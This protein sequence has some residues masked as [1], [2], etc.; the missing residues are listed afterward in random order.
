MSVSGQVVLG[1]DV[2]GT[3]T[4]IALA[5]FEDNRPH[6]LGR[7]IYPSRDY[8]SLEL[9]VETFLG[10]PELSAFTS[11]VAAA[12]FA[13]AGRVENGHGRLT[14]LPWIADEA[15]IARRFGIARVRVINDFAAAGLGISHLATADFLTLQAGVAVERG[16]R[17]VVGAGTGLGVAVL[18]WDHTRYEIHPSEAGH[19]DFAPV[20][21]LQDQLLVHLRRQF[22]RVS[23]ER[24]LSGAG[25]GHILRFLVESG[26]GVPSPELAAAMHG[27]DLARA[28]TELA[29]AGGDGLAMRALDLFVA[30][31]GSFAGN[32]ALVTLAHGGVY[33]AGGIAPKI[34]DKLADGAFMRAF[35]AKGRFQP[36]LESLPVRVVM[37]DQ[38]GLYGALGEAWRISDT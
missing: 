4:R 26:A 29:V 1:A 28:I 5:R 24:V 11:H 9:I 18:D 8:A 36:L 7:S 2:G 34:A 21:A 10:T 37:N 27:G 6:V 12:C 32:M 15:Q 23:Y 19:T 38:V 14:N 25:L 22:P 33:I 3:N 35:T 16:D 30:A 17:V 31:Y 20:G 13:V